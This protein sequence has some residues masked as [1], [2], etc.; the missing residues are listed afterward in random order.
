[1]P[2]TAK[3][4]FQNKTEEQ[5]ALALLLP[6]NEAAAEA[7]EDSQGRHRFVYLVILVLLLLLLLV[8][9]RLHTAWA[10]GGARDFV[11]EQRPRDCAQAR[12][13]ISQSYRT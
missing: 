5:G 6:F 1:M 3:F 7:P 11:F 13:L 10:R 2:L 9:I 12:G 4:Q 8:I